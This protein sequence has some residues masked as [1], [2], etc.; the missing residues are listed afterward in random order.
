MEAYIFL[1]RAR[2]HQKKE[3][4]NLYN[5]PSDFEKTFYRDSLDGI[6]FSLDA[7][8]QRYIVS[9]VPNEDVKMFLLATTKFKEE[10][11]AEIDL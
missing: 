6:D 2:I 5:L 9:Q 11:Q 4:K 1:P 7:D 3:P 10:I 8:F